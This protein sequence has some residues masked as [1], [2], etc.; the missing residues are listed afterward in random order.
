MEGGLPTAEGFNEVCSAK[1][2]LL[3]QVLPL[4]RRNGANLAT[5]ARVDGVELGG[6]DGWRRWCGQ[7]VRRCF[8]GEEGGDEAVLQGGGVRVGCA[9]GEVDM[10]ENHL[11]SPLPTSSAS[12]SITVNGTGHSMVMVPSEGVNRI[13]DRFG[14]K[15]PSS[16]SSPV[17]HHR[18]LS[19]TFIVLVPPIFCQLEPCRGSFLYTRT[20]AKKKPWKTDILGHLLSQFVIIIDIIIIITVYHEETRGLHLRG[21]H[22]AS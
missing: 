15:L 20:I 13:S 6:D 18:Y 14:P 10:S 16:S 9:G 3:R 22:I 11:S 7:R 19:Y 5:A 17:L 1:R 21:S 8:V 12:R 2:S 4:G